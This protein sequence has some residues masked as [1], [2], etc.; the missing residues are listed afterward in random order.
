MM[1]KEMKNP[2]LMANITE[3]GRSIQTPNLGNEAP[4]QKTVCTNISFHHQETTYRNSKMILAWCLTSK[5]TWNC[6]MRFMLLQAT[7]C[8]GRRKTGLMR[9]STVSLRVVSLLPYTP[10]GSRRRQLGKPTWEKS[11]VF[12]NI[13]QKA[14]DPPLYL[15]ICPIM[16]GV[17]FKRVFEH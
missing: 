2:P 15:N 9:S 7:N 16:Q 6:Q 1:K 13:V 11:A 4:D 14:F 17:F 10:N 3:V 8:T 12:F 5:L